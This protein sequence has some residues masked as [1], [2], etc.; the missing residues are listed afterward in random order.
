M[1]RK[2]F[3]GAV[4]AA[5]ILIPI[6]DLNYRLTMKE[7]K[8]I[9]LFN[10]SSKDSLEIDNLLNSLSMEE[11]IGQLIMP[12]VYGNEF[13]KESRNFKNALSYVKDFHV[14]GIIFFEGNIENQAKITN[15]L[16]QISKLPLLVSS[17]FERGLGM[18]LKD[19][20][21]FPYNLALGAAD[22]AKLSYL[23]GK[24]VGL[25]ARALG[26]HQ[27]YAPL[28][29]INHNYKNPIINIRAYSTNME[30]I[31]EHAT[32]FMRG[33]H[34]AKILST[35]KHFPGH[36]ATDVDSHADLP[37]IKKSIKDLSE[38]DLIPFK[39]AITNSAHSIMIG[40][41]E[42]PSLEKEKGIPATLSKS[43]ITDLLIDKLNFN[44]LIVTDAMNMY[45]ITKNFTNED[46]TLKAFNAGNDIILFPPNVEDSY[47][48]LLKAHNDGDISEERIDRSV[49]KV[50]L[51]KKWLNIE[52]NRFVSLEKLKDELNKPL[53][54]RIA[55]EIANKSITLLRDKRNVIPIKK[56]N[57][58]KIVSIAV[59]DVKIDDERE[60]QKKAKNE[61]NAETLN[62]SSRSRK[63]QIRRAL[64]RA[65]QADLILLPVYVN[66]RAF[67]NKIGI[68]EDLLEFIQDLISLDKPLLVMSFG[69]P[70][71]SAEFPETPSYLCAYGNPKVSQLAMFNS[72][73]GRNNITGKLPVNIPNTDFTFGSGIQK[74]FDSFWE[75]ATGKDSLYSFDNIEKSMN[76]AIKDSVFPGAALAIGHK[77]KLIYNNAFGNFTY[78]MNSQKTCTETIFD[79]ASLTKVVA[80][81]TSAMKLVD[82]KMISLDD[83]V[84]KYIP[85]FNSKGKEK[86]TI[87]HLLKHQSGLPSWKPFYK[88][89]ETK[90]EAIEEIISTNIDF[91]PGTE[92]QYSDLNMILMQ[93]IVEKISGKSLN[94]FV[95]EN[96]FN[97]L[98]M[99][100]TFF[101]PKKNLKN[102]CAPT[103]KDDYWRNR[104]IQGEVHDE[105]S[106]LMNGVAGHAGLF[107][108]TKDLAK[109]AQMMLNYGKLGNKKI[110]SEKT[111]KKFITKKSNDD[112]RVFGWGVKQE[113]SS[114]GEE[115]SDNSIGH[116]GFTG[117][118]IWIDYDREI[119]VILLSNRVYPTR[120]NRKIIDF[121]PKI[122]TEVVKTVDYFVTN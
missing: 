114:C 108:T 69:N 81:T 121:R 120:K 117:T 62:I 52:D 36:G 87:E 83:K 119:F 14:G 31:V 99:N 57:Y 5:L 88:T 109:F 64:N 97:K 66:V 8:N 28:L 34:E 105:N 56:E 50:L 11:K 82:E 7:D 55:Q 19:A 15:E 93:L 76:K 95:E 118:S 59:N 1:I 24:V 18:R 115:F 42:V 65:K 35:G 25:E 46:A 89:C 68:D 43:I 3:A 94:Q 47:N 17:D 54:W 63:W 13:N 20:V 10:L 22:D 4:F 112:K 74:N 79:L 26:V 92:T 32:A 38:S 75:P 30:Q 44:G 106:A 61:L 23:M 58:K 110:I 104:L 40:H 78:K 90:E 60:F 103:E 2:I 49:R 98:S 6:S 91:E 116:T 86:I 102:K 27:N 107:S 84:K 73:V 100:S 33:M 39:E 53:H 122:H 41:L 101:N 51:A 67:S 96:I 37:L 71:I 48:A 111:L 72:I 80:T 45:A 12:D 29:D 113:G 16:Q 9:S 21:E 70:Y 77:R 85:K